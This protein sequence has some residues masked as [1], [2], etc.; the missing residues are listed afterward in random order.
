MSCSLHR[1]LLAVLSLLSF[2]SQ[3]TL[4]A[5]SPTDLRLRG[6]SVIPSPQQVSLQSEDID[7][8]GTWGYRS[9]SVRPTHI[10][11]RSLLKDLREF[12]ALTLKPAVASGKNV[13]QLAV[14]QGT[15]KVAGTD[16]VASQGYLLK[17]APGLIEVTGNGDPGL[18]YGVQTLTTLEART[19]RTLAVACRHHSRLAFTRR[20]FRSLGHQASSRQN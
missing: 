2:G 19:G 20:A 8:D 16:D 4:A 11:V 6:Y 13:V 9:I 18:L 3:L 1:G 5:P 7:F 10:A 17:I 14:V 12:H 15:V